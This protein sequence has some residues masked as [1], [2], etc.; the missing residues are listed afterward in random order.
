M[1]SENNAISQQLPEYTM[2]QENPYYYNSG[3]AGMN[4]T[5]ELIAQYR[6]QWNTLPGSPTQY[7]L[8]GHLPIY[9]WNAT[10]GF[11]YESDNV[12]VEAINRFGGSI[13]YVI[14]TP[15]GLISLSG[16][17]LYEQLEF[18]GSEL[19]AQE[20][21]YENGIINHNDP[22]LPNKDITS[23]AMRV[24]AGMWFQSKRYAIGISYNGFYHSG[25]QVGRV[26]RYIP[27]GILTIAGSYNVKLSEEASAHTTLIV[28]SDFVTL[29]S[30]IGFSYKYRNKYQVGVE[31]RGYSPRTFD[32]LGIH[33]GF[34]LNKHFKF[35]YQYGIGLSALAEVSS[36]SHEIAIKYTL[37][38]P[39]GTSVLPRIIYNPRYVE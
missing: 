29:Q 24:D 38:G 4:N 7:L 9:R 26:L 19:I 6:N 17:A 32:Q 31:L 28:E 1:L 5:L 33:A 35:I 36:G 16:R 34:S 10:I 25:F 15:A 23:S 2:I 27:A 18:K 30:Q 37:G 39:V 20:G 11:L 22:L 14:P 21:N 12:G 13:G 3:A 8:S